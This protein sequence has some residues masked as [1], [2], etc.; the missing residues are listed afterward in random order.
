MF[1]SLLLPQHMRQNNIIRKIIISIFYTVL[2]AVLIFLKL[3]L[4]NLLPHVFAYIDILMLFFVATIMRG[5]NGKIV[6]FAFTIYLILDILAS[7]TFGTQLYAGVFSVLG[8]FWFFEEVFTNLSIWTA[9]ILT[10][11]GMTVYKVL[12]ILGNWLAGVLT[13]HNFVMSISLIKQFGIEILCTALLSIPLYAILL[14]IGN[15]VT[16][17]RIRYS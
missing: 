5:V 1:Q 3:F 6:W 11:F 2:T 15:M 16:K 10:L 4:N 7:Q 13:H 8:V 9:G 17:E 12:Y 14:K